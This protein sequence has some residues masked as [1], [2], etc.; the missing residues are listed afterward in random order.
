MAIS[1]T[2]SQLSAINTRDK[3]LLV[4]AAAG[5][6]KTAT[7]AR[8]IIDSLLDKDNP[9]EISR[10][11]IVTFT[12]ASAAD[13]NEKISKELSKALL[14]DPDN[15]HL[16][17]QLVGLGSAHISTIDSFY[18]EIVKNNFGR[19]SLAGAPRIADSAETAPINR[20]V[21]DATI[22][23]FYYS[24]EGF[25]HFTEHFTN[26]RG[27]E[28]LAD[29]FISIY[30]K[31]LSLRKGVDALND[32]QKL[33]LDSAST[34]FLETKF[35]EVAL[36][37]AES[38]LN[39]ACGLTSDAL[40][41]IETDADAQTTLAHAFSDDLSLWQTITGYIKSK[42]YEEA[43]KIL[44]KPSYTKLGAYKG[45]NAEIKA[46]K[47]KRNALKKKTTALKDKYF[48]YSQETISLSFEENAKICGELHA[49]LSEFHARLMSEKSSRGICTFN[50][51]RRFVLNILCDEN[52]APSD[53]AL[54]YRDRFDYIYVDEY[55]DVDG[56]Q[57]TIF[58]AI[59]TPTNRFMVGDIK[60]S[61]YTFRGTD[62][63]I[64]ASYKEKLPPLDSTDADGYS[65]FMSN[66]FRCDSSVV[67]F[68]NAVSSFLFSNRAKNIGYTSKDDLI[69]S[70]KSDDPD[71]VPTP[72]T[73]AIT[74]VLPEDVTV[75]S[76]SP[77][78][79]SE[80]SK[81]GARYVARE[82]RKLV[83]SEYLADVKDENDNLIKRRIDYKD[84][85]ILA[86]SRADFEMLQ[87]ELTRLG[88][89]SQRSGET[90][91]FENPDV[92]LMLALLSTIDNP[93]KDV[94]LAGTLRSPFY[95]FSL[96]EIL[97]IRACCDNSYSLYD[98]LLQYCETD[99]ELG[100]KCKKFNEELEYWRSVA[101]TS[102]C[103]K[104]IKKL[105]HELSIL[106][107]ATDGS[108]NLL[109][110]Y[111]YAIKFESNS[112]KGLYGFIKYVNDLI[113]CKVSLSESDEMG[114]A[115]CVRL[116]TIH[117]SKGLEFPVCFVYQCEKGFNFMFKK[118][119]IQFEPSLGIGF[120]QHDEQGLAKYDSPLLRSIIDTK[121]LLQ[122]EEEMRLLYVAMTRA[123]ER[124]YMV[125]NLPDPKKKLSPTAEICKYDKSYAILSSSS[126]IEWIMMALSLT[127]KQD[128]FRIEYYSPNQT[129]LQEPCQGV[130]KGQEVSTDS[131]ATADPEL[132]KLL[133][134]R[135]ESQYE[136]EHISKLPAKLS[137][138]ALSPRVLDLSDE[139]TA[140]P[141]QLDGG[142]EE[143]FGKAFVLPESLNDEKRVSSAERGTATHA[144]LQFCDFENA[145][146]RGV[147]EEISRLKEK[148]FISSKY[149][150]IINKK[151]LEAF[152]NS[153]LYKR[154]STAKRVWREQRF[155]IFLP[156]SDFTEDK[157]KA[158]LLGDETIAVQG[159]IDI[160]FEDADG[161][162]VLCDYK[163]D[164]LTKEELASPHLAAH[165]LTKRH[166]EQLSYYARAIGEMLGKAPDETII[167]SLPLEDSV[168][169]KL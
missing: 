37:E 52:G 42:N 78:E 49:L 87:K 75:T 29:I 151:Q 162:I 137:V 166:A 70:K 160:F 145:V 51:I 129:A 66:N 31:L 127:D 109:K 155:N 30:E 71:H 63:S 18:Y 43:R 159:V 153:E 77:E 142:F 113:E 55:Q 21:M 94:S 156:A 163:T 140:T 165:K 48:K 34:D 139:D 80:L 69:F 56:V 130:Q 19:L 126:Y 158:E 57:N 141:E 131:Q 92:L 33:L 54:E 95:G 96:D 46:L 4:S 85:A 125:A 26:A 104:L 106:S 117:Q 120:A 25:E 39:Y 115:N 98:A 112:F 7:L 146:K 79:K 32:Y 167:Y 82:I 86:R 169:V 76:L 132:V 38:F 108:K 64:F 20:A 144:F 15:K 121:V 136:F 27:S 68:S 53:V 168:N 12:R 10:M 44:E 2:P 3:T 1:W 157:E 101:M 9:A 28:D 45:G 40:Q 11:L 74:G 148:K 116:M 17:K 147:D 143:Q 102:P 36:A 128:C 61:I 118:D 5:S 110:L 88:I 13:L 97:E 58:E 150:E 22:E 50:D 72:T 6:G 103:D 119:R 91:F 24:R 67:D 89:P 161:K 105:Y 65:L 35:G 111:E 154:I 23:D 81:C 135:F 59:S 164:Y 124:L 107:Y 84:I 93:Q 149:A 100:A 16:T 134:D 90:N 114:D 83:D 123:R 99:S 152:F 60:Q 62:P 41:L 138:S 8:R 47:D 73:V 133:L 14:E 122:V